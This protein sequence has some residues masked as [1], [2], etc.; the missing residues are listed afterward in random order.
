[1]VGFSGMII[2]Y[3]WWVVKEDAWGWLMIKQI[4]GWFQKIFPSWY[5]HFQSDARFPCRATLILQRQLQL[6]VSFFLGGGG[7]RRGSYISMYLRNSRVILIQMIGF[8][9]F[10]WPTRCFFAKIWGI[11]NWNCSSWFALETWP[12]TTQQILPHPFLNGKQSLIIWNS[13][14]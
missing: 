3:S 12:E 6:Q 14:M 7:A 1:M 5:S 2:E 8:R 11:S 10:Q 4:C 13:N 9:D